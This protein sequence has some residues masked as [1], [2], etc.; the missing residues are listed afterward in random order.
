MNSLVS[1]P[2]NGNRLPQPVQAHDGRGAL[3]RRFTTDSGRVP[4]L[5]SITGQ[6]GPEVGNDYNVRPPTPL[7]RGIFGLRSHRA[8]RSFLASKWRACMDIWADDKSL[9]TLHKVQLVRGPLLP[10][11]T[12]ATETENGSLQL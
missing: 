8:V 4:T 10:L 9:Q 2:R 3:P 7:I 5:S 11:R 12:S 1:P 6:R